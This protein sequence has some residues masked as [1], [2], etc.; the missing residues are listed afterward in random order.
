MLGSGAQVALVI[1][2]HR[3]SS[4]IDSTTLAMSKAD[5]EQEARDQG[6]LHIAVKP[7]GGRS[8]PLVEGVIKLLRSMPSVQLA[9]LKGSVQFLRFLDGEK[10]PS[11]AKVKKGPRWDQVSA[12][13]CVHGL[14]GVGLCRDKD[15]VTNALRSY[16]ENCILHQPHLYASK[17]ILYGSKKELELC[18]PESS[19]AGV[20]FMEYEA[21]R[22][23]SGPQEVQDNSLEMVVEELVRSIFNNVM[24]R[25]DSLQKMVDEPNRTDAASIRLRTQMEHKDM[26]DEEVDQK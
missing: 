2:A 7:L 3:G 6:C 17:C 4:L 13:K 15:N 16:E 11:W 25:M 21:D 10:L 5:F 14:L 19:K 1:E 12:C 9:E 24:A 18:V 20:I 22:P 8:L 26:W 23:N